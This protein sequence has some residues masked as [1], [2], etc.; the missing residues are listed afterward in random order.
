AVRRQLYGML[1]FF[2]SRRRHTRFSR[3]WN[4]DV[5]SSDLPHLA[6]VARRLAER[7]DL[8]PGQPPQRR[9]DLQ[10]D[11]PVPLLDE[12][13]VRGSRHRRSEERRVGKEW[14]SRWSTYARKRNN[15]AKRGA[16]TAEA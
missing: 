16:A 2:S 1:F 4:S 7:S 14:R 15:P 11:P 13:R 3:D 8:G 12:T 10:R 6:G 9:D 5:C